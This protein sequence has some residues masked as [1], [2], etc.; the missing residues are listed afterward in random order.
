MNRLEEL[1][2]EKGLKKSET[3]RAVGLPYTSYISYEKGERGLNRKM[4]ELFADYYGVSFDYLL[5]K[6][7][8]KKPTAESSGIET[9][10]DELEAYA[11][12]LFSQLNIRNKI[13][14]IN[15]LKSLLQQQQ[16]Q[17]GLKESD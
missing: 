4:L 10:M 12:S 15:E 9:P 14:A 11:K 1:R 17:D 13:D 2:K 8:E 5:G 7:D 16:S 3:A 6:T